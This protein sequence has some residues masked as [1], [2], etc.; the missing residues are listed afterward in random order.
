MTKYI[1]I[2]KLVELTAYSD[3][4]IRTKISRGKWKEGQVWKRAPDGRI[5]I[6]VAGFENWVEGKELAPV[7]RT[8]SA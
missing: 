8:Q 2:R 1:T 3:N 5:L 7:E 6:D 4:A